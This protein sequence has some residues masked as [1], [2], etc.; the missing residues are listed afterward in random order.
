MKTFESV[1]PHPAPGETFSTRHHPVQSFQW[2]DYGVKPGRDYVYTVVALYGTPAALEPRHAMEI[3]VHTE[4]EHDGTYT[5]Y[6][7]RGSVATQEYARRYQDKK[8]SAAGPGAYA[9]LSR[10]LLEAFIAFL[11]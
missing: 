7:N 8:P 6:F 11:G 4:P 5:V 1:A 2:A 3:A 9:W 10:G